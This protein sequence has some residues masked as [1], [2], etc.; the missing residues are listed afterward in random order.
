MAAFLDIEGAFNNIKIEAIRESLESL[1]VQNFLIEWIILMLNS[2]I[3]NSN[4]GDACIRKLVTRGTPQGGVLSPLLWL[5]AVNVILRQFDARGRKIVAYADDVVILIT[6]KFLSTISD[7][8]QFELNE[9]SSWATS[10]GLGVNP[11]KTELVLFTRRYKIE[12]FRLPVLGGIELKLANEAKY[13]GVFLDSKLSWKRN[14]QE[15][16]KRGLNAYYTCRNS[17]GKN[18]GLKPMVVNWIYT[19]VVRPILTYGCLVWWEAMRIGSRRNLLSKAQRCASIGITGAIRSTPQAALDVILHHLPIEEFVMGMAARSLLRLSELGLV[20]SI[21]IGHSK[22]LNEINLG[23][24]ALTPL[25]STDY[26]CTEVD[27]GENPTL[28]IP[29]RDQW[30]GKDKLF[31]GAS[32]FTDGSKMDIGTGAGVYLFEENV[33]E[34]YRLS[35]SCSVFQAEIL[36][37]LRATELIARNIEENT[38]VTLYVDSQAALKALKGHFVKSRLVSDC[39]KALRRLMGNYHIR[40]CWVPGHCEIMGNEVADELARN[41]SALDGAVSES[42]V[43]PP[44]GFYFRLIREWIQDRTNHAWNRRADCQGSYGQNLIWQIQIYYWA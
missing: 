32:V 21:R 24:H 44:I 33:R 41:G 22:L 20:G 34:S 18:W 38:E 15:R 30:S 25:G 10:K 26:M 11:E 31:S 14:T 3:I 6:G 4:L 37:I 16:L 7:V 19:S 27:F 17:I 39:K 28:I 35:D 1:C 43:R 13:L 23:E 9:L 2:R 40:L 42:G 8:M 36:G 12:Q 29:N 5:L